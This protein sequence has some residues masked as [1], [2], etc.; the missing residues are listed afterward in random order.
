MHFRM[1]AILG[2]WVAVMSS[3]L[4]FKSEK[5][6]DRIVSLPGLNMTDFEDLKMYSGYL[7][8]TSSKKLHY[9]FI[10]AE[11]SAEK[12]WALWLNGGPGCSSMEGLL[13]E[14]GPFTIHLDS[15]TKKVELKRNK[16]GWTK[17]ASML[18]LESPIGVGF[19]FTTNVTEYD[20]VGDIS[21]TTDAANALVKFLEARIIPST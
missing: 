8:I 15:V 7:N 1:L 14:N 3:K 2:L 10:E 5:E 9:W 4:K 18:Y 16:F 6:K 12:P 20:H 17:V 11:N 13:T 21:A 19:S